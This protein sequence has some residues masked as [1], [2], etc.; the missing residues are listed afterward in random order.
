MATVL[1]AQEHFDEF[2]KFLQV[3]LFGLIASVDRPSDNERLPMA[4]G[5]IIETQNCFALVTAAHY[6]KDVKRWKEQERLNG[7]GIMVHHHSGLCGLVPLDLEKSYTAFSDDIDFGFI[8]LDP[9]VVDALA[10]KGGYL[11]KKEGPE[12]PD[13]MLASFYLIGIASAYCKFARETIATWQEGSE[14]VKWDLLKVT[15][16]AIAVSKIDYEGIGSDP[17]TFRFALI[18]GFDDYSGT[19]G[20]PIFAYPEGALVRDYTLIGIQSKQIRRP[21]GDEKPTHLLATSA[22]LAIRMI[23]DYLRD[24]I[25]G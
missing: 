23:E 14:T 17:G 5:F 11:T 20:G 19:S 24:M 25:E 10:K 9:D 15:N 22:P 7:I 2:K 13:A 4:S 16:P 6:L 8:V 1:T 18:N 12:D 3:R 21:F